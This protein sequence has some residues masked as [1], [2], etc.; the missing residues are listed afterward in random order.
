MLTV[1]S[2]DP[3]VTASF[4]HLFSQLFDISGFYYGTE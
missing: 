1:L 2:A 4:S 3:V